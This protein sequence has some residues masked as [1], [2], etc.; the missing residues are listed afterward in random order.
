MAC[1]KGMETE[2]EF[3]KAIEATTGFKLSGDNLELYAD[4]KLLA[5][6]ESKR[7]K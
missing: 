4:G 6:L 2:Q 5:K 7:V 3:L 1:I